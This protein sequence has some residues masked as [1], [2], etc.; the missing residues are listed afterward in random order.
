M[1]RFAPK[2]KSSPP[3]VRGPV[4]P[5]SPFPAWL[6]AVL[7]VL[8]T[9]A[10]YWPALR[11]DFIN[12]DDDLYVTSNSHVQNGLTLANLQWAFC[13]PVASNWHPVTML[14][15]MLDC[16][17]FG[18]KPWGHHLT[19]VLLH[20]L[21]SLLVFL[22]FRRLTGAMWRSLLVAAL[23]AVHPLHVESVAW[24]A[25]RKDVLST[26]FGLLSLI[27]YARFAQRL[28]TANCHLPASIFCPSAASPSV[29]CASRCW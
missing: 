1:R 3:A 14:A 24:V 17:L 29:C 11:C 27:F 26:C 6:P 25:E 2:S 13:H 9:L 5:R 8:A 16:Q 15:H 21:N 28:E 18:L 19:S 22:L 20:A 10:L 12:Y 4:L 23:F 7:L